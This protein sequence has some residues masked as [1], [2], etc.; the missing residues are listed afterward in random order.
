MQSAD[1]PD[2]RRT[3]LMQ[4]SAICAGCGLPLPYQPLPA[5]AYQEAKPGTAAR[6]M[7]CACCATC[8][9]RFCRYRSERDEVAARVGSK[10][11]E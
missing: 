2:S 7:P 1:Q 4:L 8:R 6:G 10:P 11:H 3:F 9:A 5:L